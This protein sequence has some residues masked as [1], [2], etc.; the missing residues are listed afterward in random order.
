MPTPF[1]IRRRYIRP[2]KKLDEE[3]CTPLCPSSDTLQKPSP[4]SSSGDEKLYFAR[5]SGKIIHHVF[6]APCA[7]CGETHLRSFFSRSGSGRCKGTVGRVWVCRHK[8]LSFEEARTIRTSRKFGRKVTAEEVCDQESCRRK[9]AFREG[10]LWFGFL[11]YQYYSVVKLPHSPLEL[12]R[13]PELDQKHSDIAI[14]PHMRM[15]DMLRRW[16]ALH[17]ECFTSD[18]LP[19][20]CKVKDCCTTA[21]FSIREDDNWLGC[22]VRRRLGRLKDVRDAKWTSQVYV[23]EN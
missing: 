8:S 18:R 17:G 3:D 12:P 1:A 2:G 19:V 20:G 7:S 6:H 14:C 4:P 13:V 10:E 21:F 15:A 5:K 23:P 22:T 16:I 11:L 9:F